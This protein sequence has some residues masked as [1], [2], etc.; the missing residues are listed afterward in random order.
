MEQNEIETNNDFLVGAQGS[1]VCL[2]MPVLGPIPLEKALRLAAWIVAVG[3]G[4]R[5]G[6]DCPRFEEI[7]VAVK[8]S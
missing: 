4:L 2:L 7:L 5:I 6:T 3:E 8:R 1:N